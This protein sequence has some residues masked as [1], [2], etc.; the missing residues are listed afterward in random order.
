MPGSHPPT[1]AQH[2]VLWFADGAGQ[3]LQG[4]RHQALVLPQQRGAGLPGP[5]LRSIRRGARGGG[6][7][8]TVLCDTRAGGAGRKGLYDGSED[9]SRRLGRRA[10]RAPLR[11][12]PVSVGRG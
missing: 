12:R 7:H 11:V 8:R 2:V 6:I 5:V 1:L 4:L 9:L 10:G 3:V